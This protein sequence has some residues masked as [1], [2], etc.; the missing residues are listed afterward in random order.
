MPDFAG[1]ARRSR[2]TRGPRR[3]DPQEREA[4]RA[5]LE[6]T[7]AGTSAARS[8]GRER[9]RW[10]ARF[11]AQACHRERRRFARA[12]TFLRLKEDGADCG[13][14]ELFNQYRRRGACPKRSAEASD[15]S[16][17]WERVAGTRWSAGAPTYVSLPVRDTLPNG[18]RLWSHCHIKTG[19]F[20]EHL[21]SIEILLPT[22][23]VRS[24]I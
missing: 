1:E 20:L 22:Q 5:A 16:E 3:S 6:S 4:E 23:E 2:A 17:A 14:R 13:P 12:R 21:I 24:S 8:G 19:G 11:P 10:G 9:V 7:H 18:D 15:R